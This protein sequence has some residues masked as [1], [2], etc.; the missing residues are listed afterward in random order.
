MKKYMTRR[1]ALAAGLVSAGS[2]IRTAH[3][4]ESTGNDVKSVTSPFSDALES[5]A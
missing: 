3:S 5:A 2:L 4:K 1:T